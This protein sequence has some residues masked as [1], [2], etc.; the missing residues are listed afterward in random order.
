MWVNESNQLVLDQKL[1][2]ANPRQAVYAVKA[3][4]QTGSK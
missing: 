4:P 2:K 3:K 1:W